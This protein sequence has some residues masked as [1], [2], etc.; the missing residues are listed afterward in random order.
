V[1]GTSV[2]DWDYFLRVFLRY[3][4]YASRPTISM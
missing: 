4:A 1:L 3:R 2:S